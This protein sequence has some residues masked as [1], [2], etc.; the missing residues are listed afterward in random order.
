MSP[1]KKNFDQKLRDLEDKQTTLKSCL[2]GVQI[3]KIQKREEFMTYEDWKGKN[4]GKIHNLA[5]S[6][7]VS[8]LGN[9]R[10]NE[11]RDFVDSILR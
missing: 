2:Q 7:S 10:A 3:L 6:S 9:V 1:F 5:K 8:N 11:N 4:P